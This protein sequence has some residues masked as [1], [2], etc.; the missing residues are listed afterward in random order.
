MWTKPVKKGE[1]P[2]TVYKSDNFWKYIDDALTAVR[3][4]YAKLSE[5]DRATSREAYVYQ[6]HPEL[7]Y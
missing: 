1:K 3:A 7:V 6:T 5:A 4:K 2:R